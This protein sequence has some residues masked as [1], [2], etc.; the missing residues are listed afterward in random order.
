MIAFFELRVCGTHF[1]VIFLY[2][3]GF[4]RHEIYFC[5]IFNFFSILQSDLFAVS[6]LVL[7]SSFFLVRFYVLPFFQEIMREEEGEST[8]K[9]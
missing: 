8:R 5:I 6:Y 2:G 1:S 7:P 9:I 3:I 4:L